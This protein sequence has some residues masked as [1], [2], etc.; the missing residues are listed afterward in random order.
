MSSGPLRPGRA[1]LNFAAL[2][3]GSTVSGVAVVSAVVSAVVFVVVFAFVF[4][5]DFAKGQRP[6][7]KGLN[8]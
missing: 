3:G 7:A 4:A 5:V 6:T 2:I 8:Y 1:V